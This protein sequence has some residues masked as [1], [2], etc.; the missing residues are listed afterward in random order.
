MVDTMDSLNLLWNGMLAA[1]FCASIDLQP[2]PQGHMWEDVDAAACKLLRMEVN[3]TLPPTPAP[4]GYVKREIGSVLWP[5]FVFGGSPGVGV[6]IG[7]PPTPG[8]CS[9]D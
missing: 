3:P 2:G 9:L 5:S 8:S 1:F 7:Q 6:L 4:A